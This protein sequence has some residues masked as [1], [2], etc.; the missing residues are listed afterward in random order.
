MLFHN[1]LLVLL[2][3]HLDSIL[4]LEVGTEVLINLTLLTP[5]TIYIDN[6]LNNNKLKWLD[7]QEPQVELVD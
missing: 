7:T 3:L 4:I 2:Q 6:F 5:S 1:L